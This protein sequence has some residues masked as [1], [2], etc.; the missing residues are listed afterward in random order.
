MSIETNATFD[1]LVAEL[2]RMGPNA[3]LSPIQDPKY[4]IFMQRFSADTLTGLTL[5]TY[6]VGKGDGDSFCWWLERGLEPILGRYSPGTSRG[7]LLYFAKDQSVYKN[8]SLKDLS[9]QDAL[10]YTLRVHAAIARADP[11]KDLR[12]VDDDAQVYARADVEPRV[13]MGEGRKLRL[14]SAYQPDAVLPISSS[15]HVAH[16]LRALGCSPETV[17]SQHAPVA[18]MLLLRDYFDIARKTCPGITSHGFVQALYAPSLG[19]AP[20]R[21]VD[22]VLAHFATVPNLVMALKASGQ[23]DVFCQL[24]LSLHEADLDWWVTNSGAIHAGRTDDAKARQAV[25]AVVMECNAQ[26]VRVRLSAPE[27]ANGAEQVW[28]LLDADLAARV[29]DAASADARVPALEGREACWPDDYDSSDTQLTVLLTGGAIRNGYIKV[30]K[31]QAL[32]PKEC[33]AADE[34]TQPLA[35]FKLALPD[36]SQI[37]TWLQANRGRIRERFQGLFAKSG[38]KEGDFAVIYKEGD[39]TYRLAWSPQ[40]QTPGTHAVEHSHIPAAI[41][42]QTSMTEPLNQILFGPPGTG[43]TYA[44]VDAAL[45]ILDP[46]FLAQHGTDRFAL[47]SRFDALTQEQRVRFV[48]FHQSFS[49][50]D[51]V[52]GLRATTDEETQQ[53]RYEVVDGVFKSICTIAEA[54]AAPQ[55]VI[56]GT[57]ITVQGR[58]IWKMSLGD[59]QGPDAVVY[60]ECLSGGFILLGYGNEVDFSGCATR[61]EVAAR[62]QRGGITIENT[63]RD[64]AVTSV[65]TFV[66]QMAKGDL[67]VVTDGN[68]KFR[69]IGEITGDYMFEPHPSLEGYGQRRAVRWLRDYTPSLPYTE[70]MKKKFSQM[71]LYELQSSSIDLD[72]LQRLLNDQVAG[73]GKGGILQLGPVGGSGYVITKVT[74]EVV[75]LAKPN[76]NQL[77]FWRGTLDVL[78]LGV[79]NGEISIEDIRTKQA[80]DKMPGQ[81]LEP[82]LVNGYSNVLAPLVQQLNSL[83]ATAL[84]NELHAQPSDPRVLIIDEINRG[85]IARIFGELITLLEPSKRAGADEALEVVLPYSKQP[86]SVPKNVYLIGT[87]NTAD[88]SL[89]GLDVALRRRFEF[90]A[91]PP[92]PELLDD[93]VV[94]GIVVGQLLRTMNQRIEALLDRD[95]CLGHSY[96]MPLRGDARLARLGSIF[97][98]Q[99]LPLLQEYFFDDWQR[100]QWVLNDH[101][102]PRELQF[103]QSSGVNVAELFGAEVNVARSPQIWAVNEEA[104]AQVGSYLGI[105]D[106]AKA[107]G[108][109]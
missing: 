50:E 47:K 84:T 12:W 57:G 91:M 103:V 107:T 43:K 73:S 21:D 41:S 106:H 68:L 92:Q 26:G 48:T 71:T 2:K 37:E 51:F 13:T 8:G 5:D 98:D 74:D 34:K 4:Q 23:T 88:R 63:Q 38:L 40:G 58:H 19:L 6:C 25:P 100:I 45:R 83:P 10:A 89:T 7:H 102:K 29:A 101:R 1:R 39:G 46:D 64:Y 31:V 80:V 96:F 81:G 32:F 16:F 54:L 61:Q 65:L 76:G 22:E 30:P 36:G 60:E 94:D 44:T 53:L 56:E 20:L 77:P 33:I 97:R 14:L 62:Y 99:V 59:T 27:E 109:Q 52:E 49:Y 66:K 42:Q 108:V 75:V 87:M 24:A 9:D 17:P 18:R 55:R 90:K 35:K 67:V 104:F 28:T 93:T 15:D 95:H 79:K 85:N 70:M 72:K 86:F 3:C 69:A 82:N 78:A 11:S 105:V